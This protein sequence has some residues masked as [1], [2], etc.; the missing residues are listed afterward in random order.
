MDLSVIL[1]ALLGGVLPALV[2]VWF[3]NREDA[4]HPEPKRLILAAF[5]AG[6]VT[7]AAV[8]PF[9]K[10]AIAFFSGTAVVLAWAAIEEVMKFAFA[11][12]TVLRNKEDDEPIDPLI[13]MITLALGF[14]AAENTLFL[15][16]PI[17]NQGFVES[18]LTGNFRFLGATLLHVLSSSV[19]GVALG[20]S[21]YVHGVKKIWYGFIG[22]ILAIVLHGAFNFFILNSDGT[23]LMRVFAFVWI[24]LVIL[25]ILFEKLK[26]IRPN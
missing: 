14:A 8:I 18:I 25:L 20:L 10:L 2:W 23:E 26:R 12:F 13:Y 7:V 5:I 9:Q 16:D 24:G 1:F 19:I 6:M 15:I 21:F 22:L 4:K 17:A 11:Y 3:W